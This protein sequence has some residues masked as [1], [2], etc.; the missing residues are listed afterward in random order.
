L[1][2][3]SAAKSIGVSSSTYVIRPESYRIQ[4]NYS[5]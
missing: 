1:A 4:W 2:Y 5:D 3:I